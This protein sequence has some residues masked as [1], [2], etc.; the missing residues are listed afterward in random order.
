[1][2]QFPP[3]EGIFGQVLGQ[4]LSYGFSLFLEIGCG[5]VGAD[6]ERPPRPN[7]KIAM[8]WIDLEDGASAYLAP[9]R[10]SLPVGTGLFWSGS[11]MRSQDAMAQL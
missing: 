2:G 5:T 8:S 9:A 11:D 7:F 10:A 3:E 4:S 6:S 1:M